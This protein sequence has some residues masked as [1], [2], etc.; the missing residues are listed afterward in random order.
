MNIED[1]ISVF[2]LPFTEYTFMSR[3]LWGCLLLSLSATPIGVFLILRKMSLTGDA[4]AHAI[5]PG[6]AIGFLVSGLSITAM[7]IGGVIAGSLVALLSGIVARHSRASED[8][9]LAAFYLLSL[10]V[11]VIIISVKGSSVDL[12]HVLFGSILALNNDALLLLTAITSITLICLALMYRALVWE[13]VDSHFFKS[14]SRLGEVAHYLFLLLV[15]LNLVAGF[16]ALG[17]LMSVGLMVLPAAI[18]RFWSNKLGLILVIA[19]VVALV[20]CF[21]GLLLSYYFSLPSSPAIILVLGVFYI[22][23][24]LCASRD[25]FMRCLVSFSP[26][27]ETSK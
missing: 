3:A 19:F 11:G 6:A 22:I 14:I 12:L 23:S 24:I 20:S 21:C 15:V 18:A 26:C 16:H 8:S 9:S 5:L 25:Y 2:Y 1:F 10:A 7:T 4:M 13:C 27:K 17:T